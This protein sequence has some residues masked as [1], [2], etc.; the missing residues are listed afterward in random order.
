M[1][2]PAMKAAI[3]RQ[4]RMNATAPRYGYREPPV[5]DPVAVWRREGEELAAR[6]RAAQL[7]D[8]VDA[9]LLYAKLAELR[10]EMRAEFA[11][12]L[13]E[14]KTFILEV[15]AGGLGEVRAELLDAIA[16]LRDGNKAK[17]IDLPNPLAARKAS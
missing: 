6:T 17:V 7:T 14:R 9:K 4:A 3:L 11:A 15:V 8:S 5:P 2:T 13:E 12:Q 16:Q 1:Y 10:D